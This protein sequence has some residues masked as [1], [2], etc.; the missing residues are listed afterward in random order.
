MEKGCFL[1]DKSFILAY[2]LK[3]S[4]HSNRKC[5]WWDREWREWWLDG[6]LTSH[7]NDKDIYKALFKCYGSYC[8][9]IRAGFLSQGVGNC[10]NLM[11]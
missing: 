1:R 8:G 10:S 5:M 3:N 7:S 9:P 4:F 2:S 11:G 6:I